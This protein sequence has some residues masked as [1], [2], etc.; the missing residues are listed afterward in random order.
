MKNG[1]NKINVLIVDDHPLI[2]QGLTS[3][4]DKEDDFA[5]V[6]YPKIRLRH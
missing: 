2:Q 3:V 4:L 6:G 1:E 5:M